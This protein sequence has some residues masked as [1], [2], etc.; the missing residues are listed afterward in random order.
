MVFNKNKKIVTILVFS[1]F[2][3][4]YHT[5]KSFQPIHMTD[6]FYLWIGFIIVGVL[7]IIVLP[8]E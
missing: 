3:F 6:I 8:T 7:A 5:Q 4:I 1:A 2:I